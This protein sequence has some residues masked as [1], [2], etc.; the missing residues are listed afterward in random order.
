M[1]ATLA[2]AAGD[3]A[4]QAL[5]LFQS[6][7]HNGASAFRIALGLTFD[8][9]WERQLILTFMRAAY[10]CSGLNND[11]TVKRQPAM[12]DALAQTRITEDS[13]APLWS[14]TLHVQFD[15]GMHS[16]WFAAW[17]FQH[18][19]RICHIT[20]VGQGAGQ[21]RGGPAG[22]FVHPTDTSLNLTQALTSSIPGLNVDAHEEQDSARLPMDL[23]NTLPGPAQGITMHVHAP[24]DASSLIPLSLRDLAGALGVPDFGRYNFEF[25][26]VLWEI[27]RQ[28]IVLTD[29]RRIPFKRRFTHSAFDRPLDLSDGSDIPAELFRLKNGSL[30]ER[31]RYV[32]IKAA[33]QELTQ[34]TLG[35]RTLPEPSHVSADGIIIEPVVVTEQAE[36]P[37]QFAGAGAQEALAL[38]ALLPGD[39]GR[40]VVLDEPAVNVE[41]TMQRRLVKMLRGVSQCL[42][43]THSPDLVTVDRPGDLANIVRLAPTPTGPRPMRA[44]SVDRADWARWFKLLEPAHVRALLF[45][46]RVILCE[47]PTEVGALRQ[48]WSDTSTLGL[49][50]PEAA[51]IPIISVNGDSCFGG[52]IEYLDAFG[53]PWAA[54]ADG[55]ALRSESYLAKQLR[56]LGHQPVT[57]MP[58]AEDDFVE[59]REYWASAGVFTLADRF[60]DDGTHSGEF[61]AFLGRND[62]DLLAAVYSEIG[63]RSKPQIGALFAA[64][65]TPPPEINDLY[66]RIALS[67]ALAQPNA[68]LAE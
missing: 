33:F 22:P 9:P 54:I 57:D 24:A 31:R 48:W 39:P 56:K 64:Q 52:Y 44:N 18:G 51:N 6:A 43:I 8:Q 62:S 63:R 65:K 37:I 46:N 55:P 28:Q 60:G 40:V 42:I 59:W 20:L 67:L 15:I 27:L 38:C 66:R 61:E 25:A 17:E 50:S 45:A 1:R 7:G 35:L 19:D 12:L 68:A 58:P 14:G 36:M 47:G 30:D 34:R 23:G 26:H 4:S 29:N 10:A 16:P 21:L 53:V 11:A 41:P 49:P 2:R 32:A 13:L 5:E 3:Q